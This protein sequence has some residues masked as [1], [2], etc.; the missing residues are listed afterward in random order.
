MKTIKLTAITAALAAT[1]LINAPSAFA[2]DA[3]APPPDAN[4]APAGGGDFRQR[5]SERLKTAL[6]ASDDE[7]SVIQPLLEKL[8]A[9]RGKT[10]AGRFG[11]WGGRGGQR[12][13]DNAR[14]ANDSAKPSADAGN[15]PNRPTSPEADA[16]KAALDAEGST[17]ADIK[18][19]LQ[20]LRDSRKK[21]AAELDQAQE[22]LRKVL[23]QHQEATLVMMGV[24]Q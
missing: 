12:G 3:P 11:G 16:L 23:S 19:K 13:G 20:A 17:P 24:L 15:R 10:M 18:T 4:S 9:A 14:P 6:K 8:Q 21:A 1:L 22:D 7:W 5:M 2:Q